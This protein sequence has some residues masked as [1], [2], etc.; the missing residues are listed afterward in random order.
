MAFAN[1]TVMAC[2]KRKTART[3]LSQWF[4]QGSLAG[5]VQLRT[6]ASLFYYVVICKIYIT[7]MKQCKNQSQINFYILNYLYALCLFLYLPLNQLK[8]YI[9]QVIAQQEQQ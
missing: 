7:Y 6:W 4:N 2:I 1:D 3:N 8:I 9:T 5:V